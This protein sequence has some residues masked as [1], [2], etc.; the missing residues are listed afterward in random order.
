MTLYDEDNSCSEFN[1]AYAIHLFD[2]RLLEYVGA[3]ESARLLSRSPEYC[4]HHMGREKTL[5]AV[6]Q[7][8]H[9]AG[10]ILSNIQVLQQFVTSLNW[11]SSEVM[12][13][14][15]D[16]EPFPSEAVLT[17]AP[18]HRVRRADCGDHPVRRG[19][20]A[21]CCRRH[22]TCAC[23]VQTVSR[24]SQSSGVLLRFITV[25]RLRV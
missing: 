1:P 13:V 17:V 4:L 6:L 5:S 19:F 16:R 14:A 3:S 2:P 23:P 22:A 15:F 12:G 21:P 11:M 10:L 24:I 25:T 7:L 9:D 8:Q 20:L 18:A